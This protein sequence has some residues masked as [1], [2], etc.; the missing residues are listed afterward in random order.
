MYSGVA[1]ATSIKRCKYLE[2]FLLGGGGFAEINMRE[3]GVNRR[4]YNALLHV[5][6]RLHVNLDITHHTLYTR[7]KFQLL[8]YTYLQDGIHFCK[9]GDERPFQKHHRC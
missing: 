5:V 3:T 9:S 7:H 8:V 2:G 1:E 4:H 6:T